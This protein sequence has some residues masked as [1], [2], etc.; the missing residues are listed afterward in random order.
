MCSPQDSPLDLSEEAGQQALREH[1]AAKARTARE[2][3]GP[4]M[5]FA[6]ITHLLADPDCVRFPTT[7]RFDEQ[8]LRPG[9]FA[10]PE[11]VGGNPKEGFTLFVHPMFEGREDLLPLVC[12][13]H[14]VAINYLDVATSVEAELYGATLLDLPID[15]YYGR[16]CALADALPLAAPPE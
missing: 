14:V 4:R 16:L 15:E 13:Y 10:W 12:A 3:H 9:E 2:R 1:V 7:V 8:P 5:D 6:A 11:P